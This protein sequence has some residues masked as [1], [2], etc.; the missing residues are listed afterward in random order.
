[1]QWYG[2]ALLASLSARLM[3]D[4]GDGFSVSALKYMRLFYV[5]Y[6]EL[7][8]MQSARTRQTMPGPREASPG[9]T[10]WSPMNRSLQT[11]G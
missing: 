4:Y 2:K 9:S 10:C 3:A 6:P 7:L 1:M 8:P 5:A 11:K